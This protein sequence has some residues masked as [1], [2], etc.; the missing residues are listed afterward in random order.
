L[1]VVQSVSKDGRMEALSKLALD[2]LTIATGKHPLS[3]SIQVEITGRRHAKETWAEAGGATSST[4][5]SD[6]WLPVK[7]VSENPD[8]EII[9][10]KAGHFR[11]RRKHEG[12]TEK[13]TVGE[14]PPVLKD[15]SD[16]DHLWIALT[17]CLTC[18]TAACCLL[19]VFDARKKGKI[20]ELKEHVRSTLR[21][22]L[23]RKVDDRILLVL[24]ESLTD[25]V[26]SG[27]KLLGRYYAD[28]SLPVVNGQPHLINSNGFHMYFGPV[29]A[30]EQD[31]HHLIEYAKENEYDRRVLVSTNDYKRK[32]N[33]VTLSDDNK[34][35]LRR[36][37]LFFWSHRRGIVYYLED[38][39][40]QKKSELYKWIIRRPG[41]KDEDMHAH[42]SKGVRH[43]DQLPDDHTTVLRMYNGEQVPKLPR[44]G[45]NKWQPFPA[46][47][48][49]PAQY[50][51]EPAGKRMS[52]EHARP[53]LEVDSDQARAAQLESLGVGSGDDVARSKNVG[54]ARVAE[55]DSLGSI[56]DST[57]GWVLIKWYQRQSY[58]VGHLENLDQGERRALNMEIKGIKKKW[59]GATT[60]DEIREAKRL[61]LQPAAWTQHVTPNM[62]ARPVDLVD[63]LLWVIQEW[64]LGLLPRRI[65][66]LLKDATG[67]VVKGWSARLNEILMF[68]VMLQA[69][70]MLRGRED[71]FE[72]YRLRMADHA[73]EL[74]H[75]LC[76]L[77][78]E[79]GCQPFRE[80]AAAAVHGV[81]TTVTEIDRMAT[82]AV[83]TL[84]GEDSAAGAAPMQFVP[85]VR[86]L[87]SWVLCVS[88]GALAAAGGRPASTGLARLAY[89]AYRSAVFRCACFVHR[90][91]AASWAG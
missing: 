28:S 56:L 39:D 59:L 74:A 36:S 69:A 88:L 6:R 66:V 37:L 73:A 48:L 90:T 35:E 77:L 50:E 20:G 80:A 71:A 79:D 41:A 26:S 83:A 70:L 52:I 82:A 38:P 57:I 32:S 64:L 54:D 40:P 68:A 17:C 13:A 14:L 45:E 44:A 60:A 4:G 3:G 85:T 87:L 58:N 22:S 81:R 61:T 9:D 72:A 10:H 53:W 27:F 46:Q 25:P 24:T 63:V 30:R 2:Q 86:E 55:G 67:H 11:R 19:Q 16:R 7:L 91:I 31:L 1:L 65:S 76:S 51:H 18:L 84:C 49:E 75:N 12:E 15:V 42:P 47:W 21:Q 33:G 62:T 23:S 78:S 29:Y 8:P 89:R 43:V 5:A 34:K